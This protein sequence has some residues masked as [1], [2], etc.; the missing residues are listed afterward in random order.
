MHTK[1]DLRVFLKWLIAR[2]GS[3][4]TDVI[5][6]RKMKNLPLLL[7]FVFCGCPSPNP[8]QQAADRPE[9]VDNK[10]IELPPDVNAAF[11]E[12]LKPALAKG[13]A[14]AISQFYV[15]LYGALDIKSEADSKLMESVFENMEDQESTISIA[16]HGN[17]FPKS[18]SRIANISG[19]PYIQLSRIH[20]VGDETYAIVIQ[21]VDGV[22]I[23]MFQLNLTESQT[24]QYMDIEVSSNNI[25][26]REDV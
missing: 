12:A 26:S 22:P 2:S 25:A 11:V 24:W 14:E 20:C 3:V 16:V 4:I 8:P 21:R 17:Q 5:L 13:F 15:E 9:S 6:L 18:E 19:S 1:P 7:L 23:K 10:S